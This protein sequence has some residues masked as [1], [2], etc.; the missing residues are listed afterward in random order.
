MR[1]DGDPHAEDVAAA[2]ALADLLAVVQEHQLDLLDAPGCG[3]DRRDVEPSVDLGASWVV[4]PGDDLGHV[5]V[6]ERHSGGDDVRIV[7]G[8]NRDEGVGILDARLLQQLAVEAEP[9]HLP[10]SLTG[11]IAPE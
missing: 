11:W 4:D 1:G 6:L 8:G 5:E 2:E 3:R 7:S 9:D 10:S